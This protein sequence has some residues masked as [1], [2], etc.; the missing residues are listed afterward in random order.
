M[1]K[2]HDEDNLL[3]V[4]SNGVQLRNGESE[5]KIEWTV[6]G[7]CSKIRI[8]RIGLLPAA[9]GCGFIV[10]LFVALLTA[11]VVGVVRLMTP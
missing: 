4:D 6:S 9:A 1:N 2:T 8:V 10:L 3:A 5:L 7:G 11:V